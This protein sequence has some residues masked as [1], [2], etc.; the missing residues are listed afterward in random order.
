MSLSL[1]WQPPPVL[2]HMH[3]LESLKTFRF[4]LP[5]QLLMF[6]WTAAR[7]RRCLSRGGSGNTMQRHCLRC[8]EGSGTQ[9][10]KAQSTLKAVEHKR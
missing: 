10:V 6:L 2:P 5:A 3:L 9:K 8:H 1:T 7:K 4:M